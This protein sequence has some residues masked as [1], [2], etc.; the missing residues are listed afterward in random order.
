MGVLK[1]TRHKVESLLAWVLALVIV[2]LLGLGGYYVITV[3][4]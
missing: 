4:A 2:S 1:K 3:V